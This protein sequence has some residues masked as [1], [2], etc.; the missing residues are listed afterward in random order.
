MHKKPARFVYM[1]LLGVLIALSLDLMMDGTSQPHN[2]LYDFLIAI[3]ITVGVWEGNLWLDVWLNRRLPWV[4]NPGRRMAWHLPLGLIYS[5]GLIYLSM[6]AFNRYVCVLP[7]A[8]KDKFVVSAL[9]MGILVTIATLA[10]E[11]SIQFFVQWKRSL[12]EV[13]KY[14]AESLQAQLQ[15]LKDQ[16]NPHFL[17]NNMSVLSSLVYTD[18][19]KAVEFINQLSKVYRYVLDSRN[20]ELVSLDSELVFIRSY[21]YLLQIRFGTTI[22]FHFDIQDK[23]RSLLLPPMA[24]QLLIENA[25][26]H[27]EVSA[28]RP[29]TITVHA[30][31]VALTVSNNLQLRSHPEPVSR[32]G[33]RNLQARYRFFT[34]QTVQVNIRD[35][36]FTVTLPLLKGA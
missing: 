14:K 17:F 32:T 25:I 23:L 30:D 11:I 3:G 24:L 36:Q 33:I 29:L 13:E 27:N 20:S 6:W 22:N 19:D 10:I 31:P 9:V 34:D 5:A 18:Q 7:E 15:N 21:T 2:R 26:K 1:V 4:T 12:V 16:V 35:Q 8:I 28:E